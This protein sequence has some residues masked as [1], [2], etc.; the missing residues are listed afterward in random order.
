MTIIL[1]HLMIKIY[2]CIHTRFFSIKSFKF[3]NIVIFLIYVFFLFNLNR[4]PVLSLFVSQNHESLQ[5]VSL[6]FGKYFCLKFQ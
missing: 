3:I 4:Q 6:D 5:Y 2:L 1:S